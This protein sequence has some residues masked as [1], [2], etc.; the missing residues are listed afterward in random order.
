M[1]EHAEERKKLEDEGQCSES[2]EDHDKEQ[3]IYQSFVKR[4]M[5]KE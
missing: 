1:V 4:M 3:D 2:E 5:G